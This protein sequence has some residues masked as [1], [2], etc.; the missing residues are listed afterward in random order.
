MNQNR[1]KSYIKKALELFQ[2]KLGAPVTSEELA[3]ITGTKG[4]SLD[5]T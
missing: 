3:Q 1:S 4:M 5:T 2:S